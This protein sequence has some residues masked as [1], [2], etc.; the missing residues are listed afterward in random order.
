RLVRLESSRAADGG[1]AGLG[2][3]IARGLAR[4]HGGDLAYAGPARDDARAPGAVFV[5]DLPAPVE[6]TALKTG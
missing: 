5:L 3:P 4:A 2:L 6:A 1:G